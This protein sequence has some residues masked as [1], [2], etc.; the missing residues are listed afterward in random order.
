[1]EFAK[2]HTSF[3]IQKMAHPSIT[4]LQLVAETC[5]NFRKFQHCPWDIN[6]P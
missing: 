6:V 1:M 3:R 2:I 5:V 4:N